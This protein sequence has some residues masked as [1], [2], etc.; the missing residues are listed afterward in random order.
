MIELVISRHQEKIDWLHG[1]E[2]PYKI[3]NKGDDLPEFCVKLKNIGREAHTILFHICNNFYKLARNFRIFSKDE[4]WNYRWNI[5]EWRVF[6]LRQ[7][8]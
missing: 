5:F 4:K 6:W 8:T 2:F 7:K 1:L 3:Y